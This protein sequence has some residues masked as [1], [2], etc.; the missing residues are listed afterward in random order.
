MSN[1]ERNEVKHIGGQSSPAASVAPQSN[2]DRLLEIM[3]ARETRLAKEEEDKIAARERK[4]A[5][6]AENAK[7]KDT[8]LKAKQANCKHLKGGRMINRQNKDFAVYKHTFINNEPH[9]VCFLCRMRWKPGDTV[10]TLVRQGKKV[11][12]HTKTGWREA[13]EMM[14]NS[15]NTPTHSEIPVTAVPKVEQL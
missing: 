1:D 11:P 12:N 3:V 15:S 10:E 6:F 14:N 13:E 7:G 9:I 5:Q 2:S 4:A 8:N